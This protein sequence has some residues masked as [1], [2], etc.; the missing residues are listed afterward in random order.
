MNF[1]LTTNNPER[2]SGITHLTLLMGV[3]VTV[4]ED[5]VVIYSTKEPLEVSIQ[6]SLR[7]LLVE[8]LT[9]Q[10]KRLHLYSGR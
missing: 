9:D 8:A 4:T 6:T 7:D 10:V 5:K 2:L 3:A 1:F